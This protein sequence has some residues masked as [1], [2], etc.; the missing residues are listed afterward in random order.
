MVKFYLIAEEQIIELEKIQWWNWPIETIKKNIPQLLD[1]S[2]QEF[3][4]FGSIENR[5]LGE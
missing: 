4:D 3:L 2:I 1:D 5:L